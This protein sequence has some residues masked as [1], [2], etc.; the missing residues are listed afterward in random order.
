MKNPCENCKR[1]I[2]C[3]KICFPLRDYNRALYKKGRNGT[4]SSKSVDG[5]KEDLNR[6]KL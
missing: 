3:P 1:K 2:N 5:V 4:K 6:E